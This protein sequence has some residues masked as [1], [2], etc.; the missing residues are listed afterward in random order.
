MRKIIITILDIFYPLVNRFIPKETY[1]Y[2]ACGGG[3]LVLSWILFFIFYQFVFFKETTHFY[4]SWLNYKHIAISAYTL[5]SFSTFCIA[6]TIGFLLNRYI[7]FTNSELKA[8]VQLF[9][10]GLSALITYSLSWILLKLLI[11]V[12][13]I[14]PSIANIIASCIVVVMSY[15]LQRKFTFK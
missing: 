12:L 5:S 1:Y 14:Y 2:A 3:N 13:C 9:R 10:Y 15:I 6:F 8:K 11:E 4:F 7:V